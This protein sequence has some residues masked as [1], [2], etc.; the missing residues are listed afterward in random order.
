MLRGIISQLGGRKNAGRGS[1]GGSR[2]TGSRGTGSR[3]GLGG[4]AKNPEV[5]RG[6]KSL[7]RGLSRRGRA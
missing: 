4:A 5:Q 1:G 7:V 3:G 6:V 2:G